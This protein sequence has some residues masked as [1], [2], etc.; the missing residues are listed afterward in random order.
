M[1]Q[2]SG[3]IKELVFRNE[4]NGYSVLVIK[5]DRSAEFTAVGIIPFA[6]EGDY[7]RV[8]GEWTQHSTY[9]DQ[10]KVSGFEFC[11]PENNGVLIKYLGSGAIRGIG[12]D[13]AKKIV[14]HFGG[15]T[16]E[17][18]DKYPQRLTEVPG[19]GPKKA[20]MILESYLEKRSTQTSMMFFLSLGIS[21]SVA[22][23]IY[24]TYGPDAVL[25]TRTDPYRLADEIRGIGFR[26]ADS[27]ARNEGYSLT[28]ERRLRS[29]IKFV[30]NESLNG[31][32]H[33]FLP[34]EELIR[35]AEDILGVDEELLLT[36]ITRMLLSGELTAENAD[37]CDA[38]YLNYV[39]E[40][41]AEVARRLAV[42]AKAD[43]RETSAGIPGELSDGTVL[44]P[45]Q[46]QA[47]QTALTHAVTVITGGPGTGKTT[48]IRGIIDI[49]G[50]RKRISLCAPTGRAARRMSEATGRGAKT[51]HRLLEYGQGEDEGFKKNERECLD[52]EMVIV[53]EV[54]MV[55]IFLMRALLRA[56]APGTCVIFTGDAD[57][58]P[59]VGAGNVL[60]DI[61]VCGCIPVVRLSQ[62]FRQSGMSAIVSNAHLINAG[63]MPVLNGK[64]SD[65]FMETVPDARRA[66][67]STVEL[68][69][70]RLPAYMQLDPLRDIQVMAPM[71]KGDC[72]VIAMN[73]LLQQTLN[74]PQ[75]K[76]ELRRGD[77][78]F[79]VGDKVMQTKNDYSICW[80]KDGEDGKGVYNGDIGYVTEADD[81]EGMLLIRFEDDREAEYDRDML[82]EV[83][84]AYCISVHKS[85]GSEFTCVVIPLVSGPPMLMTRNLLYTAV[86]RAKKLVVLTGRRDCVAQMV[87]NDHIQTRYSSLG[88]KLKQ[89]AEL[90]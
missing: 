26:T 68:V 52:A 36:A 69:T 87:R 82:D 23:K 1:P 27:I 16:L 74:P 45:A 58:L 60:K 49:V 25:I 29:G 41:E 20:A 7:V 71:K 4:E 18:L 38:I 61:I 33:T 64:G 48:L 56:L 3:T 31:D 65:F 22:L 8:T 37:G 84:L 59:S 2:Y 73:A 80:T 54:S 46:T 10:L 85:Q 39:Y 89:Y 19:I 21:A 55:D 15:D 51:I 24:K 70:H 76:R 43:A 11:M 67:L 81:K 72:G 75:G 35:Q 62:V 12:E 40:C 79:R 6:E 30:L 47:L 13:T 32:G 34:K 50:K 42:L 83:E 90:T 44:S 63:E 17:V 78:C 53:D 66:A 88:E 86:T 14:K 77:I 9:G 57:Q 28:D 5:P